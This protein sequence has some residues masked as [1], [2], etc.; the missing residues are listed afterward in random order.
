MDGSPPGSSVQE[1][2]QAIILEC[3]AIS[4]CRW[5]SQRRDWTRH[6]AL[7]GG[8]ST[9]EPAGKPFL[10][11]DVVQLLSCVQLFATPRSIAHQVSCPSLSFGVCSNSCPLNQECYPTVSFSVTPFSSYPKYWVG[12]K[13]LLT[14]WPTQYLILQRVFLL[15]VR[16]SYQLQPI[17]TWHFCT[18]IYLN[19][20][21]YLNQLCMYF[22]FTWK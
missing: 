20:K 4:F 22:Y 5:P 9:T 18:C 8:F 6:S 19:Q 16:F 10:N 17:I 3:D 2:S 1:I 13:V 7:A 14:F 11:N 12:Q 21:Q 15:N